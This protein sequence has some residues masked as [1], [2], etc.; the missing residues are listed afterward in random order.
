[1]SLQQLLEGLRPFCHIIDSHVI[2]WKQGVDWV[3]LVLSNQA[4]NGD[5]ALVRIK[6]R[7][8]GERNWCV[9]D[10]GTGTDNVREWIRTTVKN[11]IY[12]QGWEPIHLVLCF[13]GETF[14]SI[15]FFL[16]WLLFAYQTLLCVFKHGKLSRM[17]SA[18]SALSFPRAT[19][20][21]QTWN[22]VSVMKM[23]RFVTYK[24]KGVHIQGYIYCGCTLPLVV[25][26]KFH[27]PLKS[28]VGF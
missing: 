11:E 8:E 5:M 24:L 18:L 22:R 7:E 15:V 12:L 4:V 20:S 28:C 21:T 10:G 9:K 17:C 25:R 6:K 19:D 26:Q 23:I 13:R 2:L 27:C 16:L 14:L 1:M 3:Y